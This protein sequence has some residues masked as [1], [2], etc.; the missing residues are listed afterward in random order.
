MYC[1]RDLYDRGFQM[2]NLMSSKM[3]LKLINRNSLHLHKTHA[4]S[5]ISAEGRSQHTIHCSGRVWDLLG[6]QS[7][8]VHHSAR[9]VGGRRRWGP[10]RRV[11]PQL[12]RSDCCWPRA[13]AEPEAGGGRRRP[14]ERL[15]A[16]VWAPRSSTRAGRRWRPAWT[17]SRRAARARWARARRG[18]RGQTRRWARCAGPRRHRRGSRALRGEPGRR[19]RD[20]PSWAENTLGLEARLR[21]RPRRQIPRKWTME[22]ASGIEE[23]ELTNGHTIQV[24]WPIEWGLTGQ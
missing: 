1:T 9:W 5:K 3:S 18:T 8:T 2:N 23:G 20:W 19:W 22:K 4:C 13:W 24:K 12:L 10:P 21:F 7:R 11:R 15:S 17:R 14:A 16:R 6:R